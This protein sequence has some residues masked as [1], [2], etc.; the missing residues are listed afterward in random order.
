MGGHCHSSSQSQGEGQRGWSREQRGSGYLGTCDLRRGPWPKHEWSQRLPRGRELG[1]GRCPVNC[2]R[3]RGT[4]GPEGGAATPV[5]VR[6]VERGV[7]CPSSLPC[8]PPAPPTK[9]RGQ[10]GVSSRELPWALKCPHL[11]GAH[12]P[13]LPHPGP[14]P[15]QRNWCIPCPVG[16][17]QTQEPPSYVPSGGW[18]GPLLSIFLAE[19]WQRA[20]SEAR[21]GSAPAGAPGLHREPLGLAWEPRPA[22]AAYRAVSRQTLALPRDGGRGDRKKRPVSFNSVF[23]HLLDK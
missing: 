3:V 16:R 11:G 22:G 17:A 20:G 15:P 10:D 23:F 21:A 1:G 2:Q 5:L 14:S 8:A 4:S 18:L 13:P 6:W 9:R 12:T 19:S 7:G